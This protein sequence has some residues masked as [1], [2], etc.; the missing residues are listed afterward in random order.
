MKMPEKNPGTW[1]ELFAW[2]AQLA[3][4]IYAPTLSVVI[5]GLRVLYGGGTWRQV[6]LEGALCGAAT[7]AIKP[8]LIWLG[9]PADLA[10]F[11]GACFGFVGVEKL[12]ERADQVLGRKVEEQ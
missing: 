4:H 7:L 3:P 10:V 11:I 1:A 5:A 2:A 6:W 9:M 12:R 8:V